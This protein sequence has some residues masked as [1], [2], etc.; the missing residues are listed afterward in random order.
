[1]KHGKN[2]C[3]SLF[4]RKEGETIMPAAS[5]LIKPASA[6][7]NMDCG[8]CFYK[9]LSSN[10]KEYSLGFMTEETLDALTREAVAYADGTLTFAFQGGEPTLCGLDFFKNAVALQQKYQSKKPELRMENTIQTNG[11][12]LDEAWCRFFHEHNFLVGLSLDG[13]KKIHDSA[14]VM[15]DGAPSFDRVMRAASLMKQYQVDFNILTVVTEELAQHASAVYRFYKRN[16]YPFVQLIPCMDEPTRWEAAEIWPDLSGQSGC[17][18]K[19]VQESCGNAGNP[20]A[21]K[22]ESYGRFLCEFFDLWYEDFVL[23]LRQ[24]RQGYVM[25]VRTFSNLAQ[26]AA[27]YP[28]E[29]CGMNGFCSCYFAVEGDGSIF[30]CDFYCTDE[31]K[32]GNAGTPFAR[33]LSTEKAAAFLR[34]GHLSEDAPCHKCPY[35]P[36]CRGGCRR[37]REASD[38][39]KENY[40]CAGFQMFFAHTWER[41]HLLGSTIR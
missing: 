21:V 29:E 40:L 24:G 18:H 37:W 5:I 30:P 9:V 13:P 1:M 19:A 25:D 7:C 14:R 34:Q 28:P 33:M 17:P 38:S 27:G 41:L 2:S 35:I 10:R 23:W 31:W 12:T 26:M 32:L 16:Q 39:G 4:L 15:G 20:Y 8:Y 11:T 6:N 3:A 36:L 22:P